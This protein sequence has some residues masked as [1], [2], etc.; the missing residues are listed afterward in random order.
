MCDFEFMGSPGKIPTLRLSGDPD[1]PISTRIVS[2]DTAVAIG[3]LNTNEIIPEFILGKHV[4]VNIT[5]MGIPPLTP[6]HFKP[7]SIART[8][9]SGIG[10]QTWENLNG[11]N[12]LAVAIRKCVRIYFTEYQVLSNV[13]TTGIPNVINN[14]NVARSANKCVVFRT[15]L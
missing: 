10:H 3:V 7:L 13:P 2:K 4:I 14:V 8:I 5:T 9:G 11:G 6:T 15:R 12:Q 1:V